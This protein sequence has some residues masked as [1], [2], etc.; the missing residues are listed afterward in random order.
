M[1]L[2]AH[3]FYQAAER[4]SL[5]DKQTDFSG[6][7]KIM[8]LMKEDKKGMEPFGL[9]RDNMTRVFEKQD[10]SGFSNPP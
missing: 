7:T 10:L 2:T 4:I 6:L 8:I 9:S 1:I 5:F 3:L